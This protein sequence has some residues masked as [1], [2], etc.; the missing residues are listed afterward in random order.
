MSMLLA[1]APLPQLLTEKLLLLDAIRHG[2]AY[3]NLQHAVTPYFCTNHVTNAHQTNR[4]SKCTCDPCIQ[5][6]YSMHEAY[7]P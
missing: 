7:D 3:S 1:I 6:G 5:N 2:D 4:S